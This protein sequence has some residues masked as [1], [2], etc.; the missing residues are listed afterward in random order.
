[1]AVGLI[2]A[3][4]GCAALFVTA[5]LLMLAAAA[6]LPEKRRG[7]PPRRSS[8]AVVIPAHNESAV[9][10]TTVASVAALDYPKELF[11]AFVIADNCTDDTADIARR[12]GARCLE[13]RNPDRRGK[14]YALDWAFA[15]ILASGRHEA[16]V[17]VDADTIVDPGFLEAM[18]GRLCRGAR[19]IQGYYD[20]QHPW[21]SAVESLSYLGFVATRLLRY[22][23]RSRLGWSSNLLGNGMCFARGLIERFGWTATSILEDVEY[24]M[25]LQLAGERVVFAEEAR[26]RAEIPSTLAGAANQRG[27]W[28]IGKLGV[29]RKYLPALLRAAFARRDLSCF[30]AAMDLLIPP[31]PIM[32]ALM[33]A[34]CAAFFLWGGPSFGRVAWLATAGG[35]AVYTA[36]CLAIARARPRVYLSLLYAPVFFAW[37]I[38]L[39]IRDVFEK[40]HTRWVKTERGLR[41]E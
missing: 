38:L 4:L 17:V 32:A 13:R 14:G 12:G 26:V 9:I 22:R 30:D 10:A 25:Q 2:L 21:T 27:R 3:V 15:R 39:M 41:H 37:R 36:L 34:G 6:M 16:F 11:E 20:V 24:G 5:Y 31:F 40:K 8:F 28:D 1:M 19:A 7:P 33:T 35:M 23:G 29:A 18:N